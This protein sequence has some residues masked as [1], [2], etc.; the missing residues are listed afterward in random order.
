MMKQ[1]RRVAILLFS[2]VLCVSFTNFLNA[3]NV[4]SLRG[5]VKDKATGDPLAG[6]TVQLTSKLG[7]KTTTDG[8]FEINV[9]AEGNYTLS[10]RYVGYQ[11]YSQSITIKPGDNTVTV[12]LKEM[13][14]VASEIVVTASKGRQEKRLDA[15][16]TIEAVNADALRQTAT[17]SPLGAVAKLKGIDF[18]ERG[19]NTVD[20][21]SRGLN[22]QFN[23]RMLT[24][25]DGRLATLP[26][27]GLPQ[28]MLAPNPSSDIA[29]IEVVVGPAAALYG[30]NAHAGVVNMIT[31][32]PFDF[33][34]AEVRVKGGNQSL[35]DV[36]FRFADYIGDFGFKVTAQL[37]DA[38][39][40][41]AGNTF[42]FVPPGFIGQNQ[43]LANPETPA[44]IRTSP[45]TIQ[46]FFDLGYAFRENELTNNRAGLRKV[47]GGLFYKSEAFNAKL[48]GGYSQSTGFI[49]SNFGVLEANQ[50]VI[51]YQNLQLNGILKMGEN[52]LNWFAQVTRTANDAGN[53]FQI[54]DKAEWIAR[55][56]IAIR[57]NPATATLSRDQVMA[58]INYSVVD[59]GA[60]TIDNSSM[61]DSEFQLRTNLEGFDIVGGFQYRSYMPEASYLS[62]FVEPLRGQADNVVNLDIDATEIGGYLQIDKKLS[63]KFR[64]NVAGRLDKHTYYDLQFSPKVTF[65]YTASTD[66]NI[67]IGYNRAFKVPVILENHLYL[68]NGG[69]RGNVGGYT[70][71]S[72]AT[73]LTLQDAL[74]NGGTIS[75]QYGALRPEVV[76]SVEIGYKGLIDKKL[77]FDAVAYYSHYENFISPAF[78]VSNGVTTFAYDQRTGRRVGVVEAA[79]GTPLASGV[80]GSL[81]TY[82]NYGSAD[83]A[84]VDIGISY[85]FSANVSLEVSASFITL[86]ASENQF[87]SQGIPLTLNV[88]TTKYKAT[89]SMRNQIV[90]GTFLNLHGRHIPG[91]TF[92]AGR[93]NGRLNDRTVVDLTVG[94]EWRDEGLTFQ[95]GVNNMFDNQTPDVLGS[96]IM[97]RFVMGQISKTFGSFFN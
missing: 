67:R 13:E 77:F 36:N 69:A 3:Q 55:Q 79:N 19:I 83:I 56:V 9:I 33:A 11:N 91:Y 58:L 27:L 87:E 52:D 7:T 50:Y 96:P 97:R 26:G 94:Y 32:N 37:M 66:H 71:V 45:S 23:T 80:P 78:A 53:S 1:L 12:S 8:K 43:T 10:V 24:L 61:L 57:S 34:G 51:N 85:Y 72:G 84:G 40:F 54:H 75:A 14:T 49:G 88:P 48:A 92:Q 25:I 17:T 60:A 42:M 63:D 21:T 73:G 47:D 4:G 20:I 82:F 70:V 39:Q 30:P 44:A 65:L 5:T 15:P 68:F 2:I 81:T 95:V 76:N 18:V 22:T 28:F 74:N 62:N 6:A 29:N 31:K 93:W 38:E 86:A 59:S 16:V 89:L 41:A 46:Q 35:Y 90:D 64:F